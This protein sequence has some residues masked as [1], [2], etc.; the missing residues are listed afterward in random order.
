MATPSSS[1]PVPLP[2]TLGIS[3]LLL[4]E[5]GEM[6]YGILTWRGGKVPPSPLYSL[7]SGLPYSTINL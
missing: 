5:Q 2:H 7:P 4:V 6:L 1:T 3:T